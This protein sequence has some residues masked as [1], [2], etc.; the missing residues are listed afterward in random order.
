M[1]EKRLDVYKEDCGEW[2]IAD[3]YSTVEH[4]KRGEED[5]VR[6]VCELEKLK[7]LFGEQRKKIE[8]MKR[9][10][11]EV[12][13]ENFELKRR[14]GMINCGDEGMRRW[15]FDLSLIEDESDS[16][17]LE[18]LDADEI[19]FCEIFEHTTGVSTIGDRSGMG[20]LVNRF[21]YYS[22]TVINL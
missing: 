11:D 21:V 22:H 15:G 9:C 4:E 1:E 18:K 16:G 12:Q 3:E 19:R 20:W 6:M 17:F 14:V 8:E 2:L 5:R 10:L 7:R 13:K